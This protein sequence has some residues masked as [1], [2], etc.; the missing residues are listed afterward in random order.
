[1]PRGV[2]YRQRCAVLQEELRGHNLAVGAGDADFTAVSWDVLHDSF[3]QE[4]GGEAV[5][6]KVG[7][8]IDGAIQGYM[9]DKASYV[10][11]AGDDLAVGCGVY[12]SQGIVENSVARSS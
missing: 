6:T 7:T 3:F 8:L 10:L 4:A 12:R 11:P 2:R 5:M 1:M 9:V